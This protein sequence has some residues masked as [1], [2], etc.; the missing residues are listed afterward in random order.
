MSPISGNFWK[1]TSHV[2]RWFGSRSHFLNFREAS[3]YRLKYSC[4][5]VP[6]M[7]TVIW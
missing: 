1:A 5:L 7:D 4:S 2:S 6:S 3:Q